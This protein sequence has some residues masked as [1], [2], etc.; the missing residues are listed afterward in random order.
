M[1]VGHFAFGF[2]VPPA[3]E[4]LTA[5]WIPVAALIGFALLSFGLLP[6]RLEWRS[7]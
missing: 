7:R 2:T 1:A 5:Y 3:G 4:P 6:L